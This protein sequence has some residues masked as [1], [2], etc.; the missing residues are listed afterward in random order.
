MWITILV[1]IILYIFVGIF[2]AL[3]YDVDSSGNIIPALSTHG[4]PKL[5]TAITCYAFSI[6]ILLPSIPVNFIVAENNLTQNEILYKPVAIFFC[7]V[8]PWILAIPFQTGTSLSKFITWTGLLFVSP[9]NFII[10]FFIY[11]KC[12]KFRREYNEKRGKNFF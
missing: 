5:L 10:P 9:A 8:L 2:P 4:I 6:V 3:S 7:K 12:L 1:S 11:L